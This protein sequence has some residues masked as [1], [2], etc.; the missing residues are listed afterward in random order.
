MPTTVIYE[1]AGHIFIAAGPRKKGIMKG[2]L[3]V[4]DCEMNGLGQ[5][6]LR[7]SG[8]G[9]GLK[10]TNKHMAGL[11]AL[12]RV[13]LQVLMDLAAK[14]LEQSEKLIETTP[15]ECI[16]VQHNIAQHALK[17]SRNGIK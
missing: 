5:S 9:T 3:S 11:E 16:D 15:T 17:S 1:E 14:Y 10:C 2:S 13:P 12:R 6:S 8:S 7:I 4:V